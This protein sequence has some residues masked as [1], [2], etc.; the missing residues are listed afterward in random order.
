MEI[1]TNNNATPT[2]EVTNN[3]EVVNNDGGGAEKNSPNPFKAVNQETVETKTENK[4]TGF[5]IPEAFKEK[6][7]VK[8]ITG[9]DGLVNTDKLFAHIDGADQLIGKKTLNVPN[10]ENEEEVKSFFE[11]T[12][13]EKPEAYEFAEGSDE[14]YSEHMRK[15]FYENGLSKK[16]ADGLISQQ[17]AF[18]DE[19]VKEHYSDESFEKMRV[20]MFGD[21]A[22]KIVEDSSAMAQLLKERGFDTSALEKLP[23]KTALLVAGAF[24]MIREAYGVDN[25]TN[26]N[27]KVSS[28]STGVEK[29]SDVF[30]EYMSLKNPSPEQRKT[31]LER[32]SKAKK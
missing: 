3:T 10:W 19:F 20:E 22:D 5:S 7:W 4:P 23:N 9:E 6:G 12:R 14:K 32:L 29:H 27:S 25:K 13:P 1:E 2:N 17:K 21:K 28:G 24:S 26:I 11:K 31:Y 15:A 18:E 30:K 8:K 16:Q